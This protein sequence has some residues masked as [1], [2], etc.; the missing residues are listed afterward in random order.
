MAMTPKIKKIDRRM[1]GH[2]NFAYYADYQ[3]ATGGDRKFLETRF[4]CTDTFGG[5]VE[6]DA[7]EIFPEFRN[8]LWSWERQQFGRRIFLAE[9][10]L[11][12]FSLRWI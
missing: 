12:I 7:W 9:E 5:T 6:L 10:A 3:Y 8:K 4:W 11:S 2:G 1:R